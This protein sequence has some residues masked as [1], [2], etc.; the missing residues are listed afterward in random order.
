MHSI[1]KKLLSGALA[2]G[3]MIS[4]ASSFAATN[5][6]SG[7]VVGS[8]ALTSNVVWNDAFPGTATGVIN[9][10]QVKGRILPV[11]N[12]VITGSGVIDFGNLSSTTASTGSVNI[13]LGTNAV[14]GASVTAKSTNGGLQSASN[15][16]VFV[17]SLT[18]DEVADSYKFISSIVAAD[19]SSYISFSQSATLNSEVNDNTTSHI[20]Y[21]SNKPQALSGPTD[22][23]SFT[24]TAQ[25]SIETPAGDYSDVVILTVTGNF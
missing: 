8:G 14:N 16:T 25:P 5:I 11:L 17:N 6:G 22:D 15:P 10:L 20:L 4:A 18:A 7:V 12:M 9:G 13:E 24:V 1:S 19:D 23:F 2:A 21:T 3:M